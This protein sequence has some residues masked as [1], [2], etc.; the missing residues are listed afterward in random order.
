MRENLERY[1][2]ES[3]EM[4]KKH[5][6]K[7]KTYEKLVEKEKLEKI[8]REIIEDRKQNYIHNFNAQ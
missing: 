8:N 2:A 1:K 3:G 4:V 6:Y 5:L 7:S